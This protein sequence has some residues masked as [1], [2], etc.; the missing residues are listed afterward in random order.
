V[1][2]RSRTLGATEVVAVSR[3]LSAGLVLAAYRRGIFPWPVSTR[4]IP[5]VSPEPRAIFPLEPEPRWPRS[6]RKTFN[7]GGFTVTVDHAFHQVIA[8]CGE[9]R[10]DGTWITPEIVRTYGQLHELG[11]AHSVEV[12]ATDDGS[13]AG[14]LYGIAIGGAFAGES[15]FHR[16][17]DASK[18][19]F[20]ALVE[21]LRARG[22]ALLD[23]QVLTEHLASLGCVAVP[24]A[25]FLDRLAA[26]AAL[27]VPFPEE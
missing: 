25:E 19:A 26:A 3:S 5:W 16:R 13:L 10:T 9:T 1:L 24:R 22:F 23:A 8:A 20:V 18:V 17:T 21:R 27:R 12:W 11:W 14:G 6:L 2:F 7:R 15:M 4:V